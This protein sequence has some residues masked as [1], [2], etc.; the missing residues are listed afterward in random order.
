MK[1][2]IFINILYV[3]IKNAILH[4]I[5]LLKQIS[6]APAKEIALQQYTAQ[7]QCPIIPCK[8]MIL[9]KWIH[10]SKTSNKTQKNFN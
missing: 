5:S 4:L 9:Q 7:N 8:L 6:D 10:Q 1:S 3:K 2:T